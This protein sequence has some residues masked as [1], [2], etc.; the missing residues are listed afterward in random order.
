MNDSLYNDSLVIDFI[1]N[2]TQENKNVLLLMHHFNNENYTQAAYHLALLK[3]IQNTIPFSICTLIC[4]QKINK[5]KL[6]LTKKDKASLSSYSNNNNMDGAI[7]QG[8]MK[9]NFGKTQKFMPETIGGKIPK[10]AFN[11]DK[12]ETASD[13]LLYP[14]PANETVNIK[15]TNVHKGTGELHVKDITG[16]QIETI[17]V[18]NIA[19]EFNFSTSLFKNGVYIIEALDANM[20]K[21]GTQKLI[22]G[23]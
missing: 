17:L 8:Y 7:A 9:N 1:A 2:S 3:A 4:L 20:V 12:S 18:Q 22:V 16:K 21:V 10:I 23:K 14:Q 19:V 11:V 5:G 13:I 6:E 15:I